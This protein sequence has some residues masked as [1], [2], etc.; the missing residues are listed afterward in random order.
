[1]AAL[2]AV[3]SF[4]LIY[5]VCCASFLCTQTSSVP[6][7]CNAPAK[8][9]SSNANSPKVDFTAEPETEIDENLQ[10]V[11]IVVKLDEEKQ[12][13]IGKLDFLGHSPSLEAE[14]RA[15]LPTGAIFSGEALQHFYDQNRS[16]LPWHFQEGV[17]FVRDE[18][19]G[20]VDLVFDFRPCP[21]H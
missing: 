9:N 11:S 19:T 16:V 1:M 3:L 12:Y 13:S 21:S 5:S 14:L 15:I 20:T 6:P 2:C 4:G 8:S 18:E 17:N 10:R 7:R